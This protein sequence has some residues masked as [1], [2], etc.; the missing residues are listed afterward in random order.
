MTAMKMILVATN[1][2]RHV[3]HLKRPCAACPA[4][5]KDPRYFDPAKDRNVEIR[6]WVG[7]RLADNPPLLRKG[8]GRGAGPAD[9]SQR[10]DVTFEFRFAPFQIPET[11]FYLDRIREGALLAADEA[12]AKAARVCFVDV[13]KAREAA[14]RAS[15]S[16]QPVSWIDPPPPAEPEQPK[17]ESAPTPADASEDSDAMDDDS[18]ADDESE[19]EVR[20][21]SGPSKRRGRR[22][23]HH[24]SGPD[25]A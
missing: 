18:D 17:P 16:D 24:N 5:H 10:H 2:Y 9:P 22:G 25:A 23:K 14:R 19:P 20:T 8:G 21:W 3:D 7:A 4:D 6:G 1:P 13:A 11:R 12:T 15:G